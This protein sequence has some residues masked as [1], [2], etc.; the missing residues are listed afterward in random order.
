MERI[1]RWV[2]L[3]IENRAFIDKLKD[4]RLPIMYFENNLNCSNIMGYSPF[5]LFCKLVNLYFKTAY[6]SYTNRCVQY[7]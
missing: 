4:K 6:I 7:I 2:T 1:K 3:Y 5:Y